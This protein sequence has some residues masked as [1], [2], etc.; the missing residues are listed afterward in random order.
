MVG[1][2]F[3]EMADAALSEAAAELKDASRF[4]FFDEQGT[5]LASNF[6]VSTGI[7]A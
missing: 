5:I 1:S 6:T 7:G 3:F 4:L 2:R